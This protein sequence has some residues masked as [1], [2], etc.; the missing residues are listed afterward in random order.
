MKVLLQDVIDAIE[1]TDSSHEFYYYPL[2]EIIFLVNDGQIV[3][4]L[5]ELQDKKLDD[6]DD[7]ISLPTQQERNDYGI[8][9]DFI[10]QVDDQTAY[11]WLTNSIKGRGAFRMFRA[12]LNRFDLTNEYYQF[13]DDAYEEIAINWCNEY[14]IEYDASEVE[15]DEE[16]EDEVIVP[17]SNKIK[18]SIVAINKHNLASISYMVSDCYQE[19]HH[20]T[21]PDLVQ[22]QFMEYLNS[23][24]HIYS[25]TVNGKAIGYYVLVN[26]H[27]KY[28]LESIY[29]RKEE[30]RKG[31]GS[32]LLKHAE[33]I[34]NYE[35]KSLIM[36]VTPTNEI[37]MNLL[38]KNG[39]ATVEYI[40]IRK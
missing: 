30:R 13:R 22:E 14:G 8:M 26:Q 24:N 23:D 29:V 37:Y 3:S 21:D 6:L 38:K 28:L 40:Q 33:E 9:E 10:A 34:A 7:V 18:T 35:H 4:D 11:E 16:I 25:L 2:E 5:E 12:T 39:Y 19:I 31:N 1:Q 17:H 20:I 32:T 15:Y 27:D 36:H